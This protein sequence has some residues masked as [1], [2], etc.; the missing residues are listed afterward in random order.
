MSWPANAG[1]PVDIWPCSKKFTSVL[2]VFF[3]S[4]GWPAFAGH[5]KRDWCLV[6]LV[7]KTDVVVPYAFEHD[8]HAAGADHPFQAVI[9]V[10]ALEHARL[11]RARD[12]AHRLQRGRGRV[13]RFLHRGPPVRTLQ[14]A[15]ER[16]GVAGTDA[17][18]A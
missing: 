4:P 15:A 8:F 3:R 14:P 12:L 17:V 6:Q 18:A 10:F 16:R 11:H 9:A 13:G 7:R 1:D 5:D 2:I